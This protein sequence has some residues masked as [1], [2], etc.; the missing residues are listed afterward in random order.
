MQSA[1]R[2]SARCEGPCA[3][4]GV[5]VILL[6][7]TQKT[8]KNSPVSESRAALTLEGRHKETSGSSP[9]EIQ[10]QMRDELLRTK[11][12]C[13]ATP[14]VTCKS[15]PEPHIFA[16]V[17][18]CFRSI[19]LRWWS[20]WAKGH[21]FVILLYIAKLFS[22]GLCQFLCQ[23]WTGKFIFRYSSCPGCFHL[24]N[25]LPNWA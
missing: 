21:T 4:G 24:K 5:L 9:G 3:V 15:M 14:N 6:G 23:K 11:L 8:S 22:K 18:K 1:W 12:H 20:N 13:I 7:T 10:R 2:A 25:N 17:C 16:Q 19:G